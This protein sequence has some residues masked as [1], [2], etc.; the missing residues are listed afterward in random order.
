MCQSRAH[1]SAQNN[2]GIHFYETIYLE[3]TLKDSKNEAIISSF[4]S[5]ILPC[6]LIKKIV[7]TLN[8][9]NKNLAKIEKE[10]LTIC[11]AFYEF[12]FGLS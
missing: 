2:P 11:K 6:S 12:L 7:A 5:S 9:L 3:K 8:F 1:L 4:P 10:V